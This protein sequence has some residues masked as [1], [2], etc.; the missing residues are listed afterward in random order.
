M[1]RV[2]IIGGGFAGTFLARSLASDAEVTLID[3]K[4]F[5]EFTPGILRTLVEPTHMRT[6]QRAYVSF[7][8]KVTFI[9]GQVT[10]LTPRAIFLGNKRIPFDYCVI[11]SGSRYKAPIKEQNVVLAS[12]AHHL[13]AFHERMVK[14]NEVVI[15]GGGLAGVE[16]A[17]EIVTHY[18][19]IHVSL[20][21]SHER[22]L[23]AHALAT[24]RYAEH[25]LR[26]RN[27]TLLFNERLEKVRGTN[28]R[29]RSGKQLSA[30]LVCFCTGIVP[31]T[32]FVPSSW[33]TKKGH[34]IT[35]RFLQVPQAPS[36]FVAGDANSIAEEKTAQHAERQATTVLHNLRVL[37]RGEDT[38]R[39]YTHQKES[40]LLISLG[41]YDGI[42]EYK[43]FVITGFIPAFLKWAV[44]KREMWKLR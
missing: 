24:S 42:F 19:A 9:H 33:K 2:L 28:I 3:T 17:G 32:D 39:T 5:F 15:A 16:L 35:N 34:V 21:H 7:L 37:L 44:E 4:P 14:A 31:N 43:Q 18:P 38:L 12:R 36:L 6:I 20:V 40:P 27:V 10:S 22:L 11:A 26:S 41:K 25:F 8:K 1:K 30:D 29:L 23:P 13:H